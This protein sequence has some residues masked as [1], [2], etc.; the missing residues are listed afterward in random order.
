MIIT[1]KLK[2][3]YIYIEF[4][5]ILYTFQK[6]AVMAILA[7]EHIFDSAYIQKYYK[8]NCAVII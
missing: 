3:F 4:I 5:F 7:D 1:S 8:L 6:L 2:V